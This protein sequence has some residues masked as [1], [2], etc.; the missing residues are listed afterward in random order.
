ME[1]ENRKVSEEDARQRLEKG[2]RILARWIIR[3][4]LREKALREAS[5]PRD[6]DSIPPKDST[7]K[8]DKHP[9]GG[10]QR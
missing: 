9:K 2:L 7:N 5:E 4:R 1:P 6:P 10:G 3:K 8:P